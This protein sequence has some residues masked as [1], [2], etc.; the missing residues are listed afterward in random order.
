LYDIHFVRKS[1]QE[2]SGNPKGKPII[3]LH[4][5]PGGGSVPSY[6]QYMNSKVICLRQFLW[7]L[8]AAF[9]LVPLPADCEPLA[10]R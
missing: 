7:A 1:L 9:T 10:S 8:A 2:Q 4:G 3:I 5:G 6:R